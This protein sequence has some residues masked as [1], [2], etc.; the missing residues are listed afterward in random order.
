MSDI[1]PKSYILSPPEV[2][3]RS[4]QFRLRFIWFALGVD[5]E[6]LMMSDKTSML[7]KRWSPVNRG[8]SDR[9]P[10][11]YEI[12]RKQLKANTGNAKKALFHEQK[13]YIYMCFALFTKVTF[14]LFRAIIYAL[15]CLCERSLKM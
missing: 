4:V 8:T 14:E 13:G 9:L 2:L 6:V 1:L 3:W 10:S 15:F 5:H 11:L 7:C 12:I